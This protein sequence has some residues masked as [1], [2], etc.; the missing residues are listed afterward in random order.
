VSAPLDR[1]LV[2]PALQDPVALEAL[3]GEYGTPLFVYDEDELRRR[4]RDY[5]AH[6]GEGNVAYAGKA[7]LCTAMARI[8][9][10]EGL[11]LDV[12]TGGELQVALHAGFP[13]NRLIFH[14]N[15]KSTDELSQAMDAGVGRIVADS[16]DELDRLED[17]ATA[18]SIRPDVLVRVTPGVE[19]H[20]HE[21][22]ETGTDESKFGFTVANGVARNAALRVAESP[23]LE[24]AGLHSHIGSQIFVLDSYRLAIEI[25]SRLA[26]EIAAPRAEPRR[27]PRRSLPARRPRSRRGGVRRHVARRVRG[28]RCRRRSAKHPPDDGGAGPVDRRPGRDHAVP[29]RDGQGDP[30]RAHLRRRRRRDERQPAPGAVRRRV[31]GLPSSPHRRASTP[32]VLDRGE[33]L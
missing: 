31:R 29:G 1:G 2:P 7:F 27:R 28:R 6:F 22:I 21:F 15:N 4:C 18:R 10:E 8:V 17:L 26:S 23:S 24:L 25:V 30:G 12:A 32:G 14:G 20:T 3:A 11:H 19:A 16:F 13:P 9:A 5:I 33:A